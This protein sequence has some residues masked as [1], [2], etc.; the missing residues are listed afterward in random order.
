[1]T[2]SV[3]IYPESGQLVFVRQRPAFVR[4]VIDK[5]DPIT[6]TKQHFIDIEYIDGWNYPREDRIIWEREVAPRIIS[7]AEFPFIQPD[8]QPDDMQR[9]EAFV[10]AIRWS[11]LNRIYF[12]TTSQDSNIN[13]RL[14]SPFY[15][16]VQIEDYQLYT[17]LEQLRKTLRCMSILDSSLI[18]VKM[19]IFSME[20]FRLI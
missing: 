6:Q 20:I 3:P 12:S 10:N 13:Y 1:M 9:Y 17:T 15:S 8:K 19:R 4:N 5:P 11:T 16:A 2:L 14:T 7:K 18:R